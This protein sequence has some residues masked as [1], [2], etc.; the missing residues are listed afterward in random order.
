MRTVGPQ[1]WVFD[2]L[3]AIAD[4]R[5]RF[6][7]EEDAC[8]YVSRLAADMPHYAP[9]HVLCGPH[10]YEKW[11]PSLVCLVWFSLLSYNCPAFAACLTLTLE[12]LAWHGNERW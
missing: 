11:D 8:E 2:E 5:F 6:A 9:E 1:R 10:L 4:L 3:A 12:G 7:E